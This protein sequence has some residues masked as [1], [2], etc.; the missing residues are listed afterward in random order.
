[1]RKVAIAL[2]IFLAIPLYS[3]QGS[4]VVA[5]AT[6]DRKGP[7]WDKGTV[8]AGVYKNPSIGLEFSSP[9][10]LD[11][12]APELKGNPG[13]V[14]LLVTINALGESR[15][16]SGREVMSFY[17]DA[18]SYYPENRRSTDDY[19][20]RVVLANKQAGWTP[21]AKDSDYQLGG[22]TFARMDFQREGRSEAILVKA[23]EAQALV[24]IFAGNDAYEV[25]KLIASMKLKI[26][27]AAAEC[28]PERNP[29]AKGSPK[30]H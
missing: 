22:V 25:N 2:S 18:L 24:F 12:E 20:R 5:P 16:F 9:A 26:D 4:T 27:P 21:D 19:V 11:F 15:L 28:A 23:C 17:S 7:Q 1:M 6:S 10:G 8:E 30:V 3:Q 29:P 13:T 14:P